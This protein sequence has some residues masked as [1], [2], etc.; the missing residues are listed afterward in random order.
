[1][2]A[3][4]KPGHDGKR[5]EET[6]ASDKKERVGIIGV[7]RM[8]HAMLKHLVK[9]G[10]QVT[11]CDVS[12]EALTKAREAGAKS[13]DSPAALA[14]QCD[15]VILGVGYTPEVEAEGSGDGGLLA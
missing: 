3:W 8:G 9:H 2:D 4:V 12:A 13:A 7:G 10:Y 1:M 15:F 11:A 5:Q 14:K 6:M